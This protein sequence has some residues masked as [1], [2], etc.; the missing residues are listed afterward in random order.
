MLECEECGMWR[1]LYSKHKLK[2]ADRCQLQQILDNW[3]YSCGA[4]LQ[5]L[6]LTGS[7]AEVYVREI[8][9]NEPI[10]KLYYSA[11]YEPI[12]IYCALPQPFSDPNFYPQ[13]AG[14]SNREKIK[15]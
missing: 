9:C 10:E 1:L 7:L 13:C 12:C 3:S 5:D 14:C 6:N 15:K 8:T 11:K 2:A 4:Q